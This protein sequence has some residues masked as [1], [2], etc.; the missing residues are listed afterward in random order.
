MTE[1]ARR[2]DVRRALAAAV[3]GWALVGGVAWA[4]ADEL[5]PPT[6]ALAAD[7]Y[8][9][10][11]ALQ[12]RGLY[13]LAATEWAALAGDY[14]DN[15][16]FASA[17]YQCGVCLAQLER[18][19]EARAEFSKLLTGG[20]KLDPALEEQCYFHSAMARYNSALRRDNAERKAELRW[21]IIDFDKQ[22]ERFPEG[23]LA[24]QAAFY[25]C[26]AYYAGGAAKEASIAYRALLDKYPDHPQRAEALYGLGVAEQETGQFVKAA[27]TF[28]KLAAEFP[29]HG[30][31]ADARLRQAESLLTAGEHYLAVGQAKE[32]LGVLETAGALPR[33]SRSD[34]V[35]LA[36]ADAEHGVGR[37]R[38]AIATIDRLLAEHA[39]SGLADRAY[40]RRAESNA[41]CD[42]WSA[43]VTDYGTLVDHWPQSELVP[44][45]LVAR[46]RAQWK[47]GDPAAAEASLDRFLNDHAEHSMAREAQVLRATVRHA[48]G[49]YAGGI[50]D[51]DA[52]LAAGSTRP[53]RSD[54][55]YIRGLCQLAL[56]Q[57]AEAA[58]TFERIVQ[59]DPQYRA[60]DRVLYDL[61]WAYQESHD[62][63]QAIATFNRL[64][65]SHPA[66]PLATESRYR[67]GEVHFAAGDYAVA[68]THFEAA[69][70]QA[71][72]PA[73]RERAAH[74]LAWC[75]FEQ[76]E[77]AAAENAFGE[78]LAAY[79]EGAL[80]A[81]ARVMLAECQFR[82]NNYRESLDGITAALDQPGV[83]G[84][85]RQS[86]VL[87]AAQA[88]ARLEQWD[89][90][91][92]LADRAI[93]EFSDARWTDEARCERGTALFHLGRLD[94]AGRE[95]AALAAS[96]EPSGARAEFMLGKIQA[97]RG[98]ADDAIRTFFK[99]AYGYGDTS[100]PD[101][102]RP[103]QAESLYEAARCLV[104][105]ERVESAR[106]LYEELLDRHPASA[107]ADE[108]RTALEEIT[109]R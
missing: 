86:A 97:T 56:R 85:L 16:L 57:P 45:T 26:E 103:W 39:E 70:D 9:A 41:A 19:E 7:R 52:V 35:L 106:K 28:E 58:A 61:A 5:P 23:A 55:L 65:E 99:V 24:A 91:I 88:A 22:L 54:A 73:V 21:A 30:S 34:A 67:I 10:A 48:R 36:L 63:E 42:Q 77:F 37:P 3:L 38:D 29:K 74:K 93:A 13:D 101:A 80:A 78:Q 17:R 104:E 94:E 43:A 46:A 25:R 1:M 79:A 76:Q 107:K 12:N 109:R 81:D 11:A 50:A 44:A 89:R 98:E 32:A 33:W 69:F 90:C 15:P 100:A 92:E 14:P 60:M 75:R 2:I 84:T 62:A 102:Y 108:A 87:H 6:D 51:A 53:V 82:Q 4:V 40:Q 49:D 83:T 96:R 71:T 18:F 105:T 72:E 20:W 68:A 47:L 27:A 59:K 66:S 64:A 31:A 95:F 8:R